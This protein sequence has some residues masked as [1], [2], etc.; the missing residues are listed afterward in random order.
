MLKLWGAKVV[1]T[2]DPGNRQQ[3]GVGGKRS[4]V[5]VDIALRGNPI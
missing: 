3:I 4:K 1:H 2:A 5:K